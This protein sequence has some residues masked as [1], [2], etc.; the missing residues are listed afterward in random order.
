AEAPHPGLMHQPPRARHE[1]LLSW[2]LAVRAYLWLGLLEAAIALG[3]FF[4]VLDGSGWR[5]GDLLPSTDPGYLA[6]TS[7]CFAGIVIAQMINVFLCRHPLQSALRFRPFSN[8]LLL[9]GLAIELALL[10]LIIYTPWGN[11]LFGTAPLAGE[12]W[13]LV[14]P[15]AL[16]MGGLEEARKAFVRW[17]LAKADG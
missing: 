11:V 7:A 13:L 9:A 3:A 4:F 1:R 17:R 14:L 6:A 10:L 16:L 15:L 2:G 8:P 5:Y 12:V